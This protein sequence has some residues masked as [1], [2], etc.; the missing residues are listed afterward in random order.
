MESNITKDIP[1][2]LPSGRVKSFLKQLQQLASL[3][4]FEKWFGF[5]VKLLWITLFVAF[6]IYLRKE[7]KKDIFYVQNFKV[8]PTWVEQGY[9]G[10]VVKQAIIDDIDNIANTVYADGKSV[11]ANDQ[12]GTEF[13][14]D[15][16]ID[17]FN[18]KAVTKSVLAV[19]GKKNKR[20]GGYITLDDSAQTVAIQVSDQITQPVS[21]KRNEPAQK[22]IHKATLEIMKAKAPSMLIMHYMNKKDTVM[23][24]K[25]YS[26]L[27]KHR[28]FI[29]DY[30]FYNLSVSVF[31]FQ[32]QYDK[33]LMWADSLQKKLPNDKATF[34]IRAQI[35]AVLAYTTKTDSLTTRKNKRLFVE[36]L[37]KAK[38][39]GRTSETESNIDYMADRSLAGF[40]YMEKDYISFIKLIEKTGTGY[41]LD[42]DQNNMLAYAYMGQ[43]EYKKAEAALQR[44]VYLADDNGNYWDSLAELYSLQNKDSLAVVNLKIA[45]NSLQKSAA[46]SVES[47]RTDAR[48]ERLRSRKDFQTL[49]TRKL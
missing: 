31:A 47:Y 5:G 26:Y 28:E 38:E 8:P 43:K 4:L 6:S 7:Y 17:G 1:A 25:N 42:A 9:S 30:S 15:L 24:K 45:L 44:A 35:H 13:L 21:I 12:D 36:N 48:W 23:V 11:T 14:S 29:K 49:L 18:L 40:Y 46:V 41:T 22:L 19:L 39:P 2:R 27:A 10:E 33:A 34:Y 3:E 20:I 16:S 37:M 32:K